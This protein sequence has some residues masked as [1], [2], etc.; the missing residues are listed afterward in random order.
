[1]F[2]SVV[3]RNVTVLAGS[4]LKQ[5]QEVLIVLDDSKPPEDP[6]GDGTSQT[7]V[8]PVTNPSQCLLD[9]DIEANQVPGG[10]SQSKPALLD[11]SLPDAQVPDR[12][13]PF[14]F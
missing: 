8:P 9:L 6:A 10:D 14:H 7:G 5:K 13:L 1:M 12:K 4:V 2:V 3:L 11:H